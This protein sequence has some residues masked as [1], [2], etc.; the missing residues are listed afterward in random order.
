V[1][2]VADYGTLIADPA[3]MGAYARALEA[4]VRPGSV[5]VDLGTGTGIMAL[6]ACRLG[7]RRVFA[8]EPD[9]AIQVAREI[10]VLNGYGDRIE[11]F[12]DVSTR[13]TLP[14]PADIVVSDLGGI[15]PWFHLHI[16]SV[17]DARRRYLSP[18]GLMIPA[19][20]EVWATVV[21]APVLYAR[22]TEPWDQNAFELDLRPARDVVLN[23]WTRGR[24]AGDA[25]LSS[26]KVLATLD[27]RS[28]V[29]PDL[30]T[31]AAWT[32]ERAGTGHGLLAGFNRTL[33]DGIQLSN[34]PDASGAQQSGAVYETV[35]FPWAAPVALDTAD[36]VVAHVTA[37]LLADDYVWAWKTRV[38]GRSGGEKASFSQSTF[39]GTPLTLKTLGKHRSS[40]RPRLTDEGRL[41]QFILSA[42]ARGCSVGEIAARLPAEFPEQVTDS[43]DALRRVTALTAFYD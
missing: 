8:I 10:A 35:F 28:L 40:H 29:N 42:I 22:K 16:P 30:E 36:T 5:V 26:P 7:A 33:L 31:T 4:T 24:V 6:L 19:R 34:L 37:R 11:F 21:E 27:Y 18:G 39:F 32:I 3:R 43:R 23:T 9:D 20:D 12:Q 38:Q 17:A 1:Y 41:A 15:M 14:E 2:S 13:V 25:L